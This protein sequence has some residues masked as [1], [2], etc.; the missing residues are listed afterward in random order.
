MRT[1]IL[2]LMLILS[3]ACYKE[4]IA[5]N[6]TRIVRGIAYYKLHDYDAL[7]DIHV[8]CFIRGNDSSYV[9]YSLHNNYNHQTNSVDYGVMETD[10]LEKSRVKKFFP[11][12]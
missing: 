2:L 3:T 12:P 4:P 5:T 11:Y 1:R 9:R 8:T 6:D 7:F 10:F